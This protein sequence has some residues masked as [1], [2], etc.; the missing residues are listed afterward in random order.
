[1][2]SK[3]F[4][5]HDVCEGVSPTGPHQGRSHCQPIS[6]E[7]R[8]A[9]NQEPPRAPTPSLITVQRIVTQEHLSVMPRSGDTP[10]RRV[11]ETQARSLL[12]LGLVEPICKSRRGEIVAL[13]IKAGTPVADINRALRAGAG[14][15]LPIA[16]DNRTVK[17]VSAEGGGVY[18][19]QVRVEAWSDGRDE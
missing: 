9:A 13:R 10:L 19:E 4:M 6:G 7:P 17:R 11:T 8:S 3:T 1:M 12:A 5:P 16:E 15:M 14:N 18:Y 2:T